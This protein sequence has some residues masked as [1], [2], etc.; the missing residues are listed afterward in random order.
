[1]I[2]GYKNVVNSKIW[3]MRARIQSVD[4][5]DGSDVEI[6]SVKWL[7]IDPKRE[8]T[9]QI[10]V[11]SESEPRL[12]PR[13]PCRTFSPKSR[14]DSATLILHRR[15]CIRMRHKWPHC[16][17][18]NTELLHLHSPSVFFFFSISWPAISGYTED[19]VVAQEGQ[20]FCHFGSKN[21]DLIAIT[22]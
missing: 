18:L 12:G 15:A 19:T 20:G 1:M 16:K 8:A 11:M 10:S 2:T 4:C 7:S 22:H 3:L 17:K 13:H 9:L 14:P 5:I 21:V 6:M